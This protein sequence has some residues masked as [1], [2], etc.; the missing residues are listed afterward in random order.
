MNERMELAYT[1]QSLL[2]P[3]LLCLVALAAIGPASGA[4]AEPVTRHY[5]NPIG[6]GGTFV[7]N[8]STVLNTSDMVSAWNFW[9]GTSYLSTSTDISTCGSTRSCVYVMNEGATIASCTAPI[10]GTGTWA[11][12]YLE[13]YPAVNNMNCDWGTPS[14]PVYIIVLNSSMSFNWIQLQHIRRHEMGHVL[15]LADAVDSV[16]CWWD[17]VLYPIMKNGSTNC[18][19]YP[20]N[21]TASGNEAYY[22]GQWS[23]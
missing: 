16:A 8:Q 22:A 12:T 1:R 14:T 3:I 23:Y 11:A 19:S 20:Q 2:L 18:A 21:A 7:Y 13:A 9:T 17:V 15:Q 4:S 6:T 10:L 5:F